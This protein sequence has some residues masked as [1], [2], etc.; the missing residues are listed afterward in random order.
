MDVDL[1]DACRSDFE[2]CRDFL[3]N[4]SNHV[5]EDEEIDIGPEKADPLIDSL[6]RSRGKANVLDYEIAKEKYL[7]IRREDLEI[8]LERE[9]TDKR[10]RRERILERG[11]GM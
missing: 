3:N 7:E 6:S 10:D 9:E 8:G 1:P 2:A 11:M 5:V 4:W